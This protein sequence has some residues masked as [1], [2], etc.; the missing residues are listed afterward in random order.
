MSANAMMSTCD[1]QAV[2]R[3]RRRALARLGLGA[4]IAYVAP[5][6][7]MRNTLGTLA[8]KLAGRGN[9]PVTYEFGPR[10]LHSTGQLHKGGANNGVFL[11]LV[12]DAA[13]DLDVPEDSFTFG[14][15]VAAQA[16]GDAAA[17]LQRGRR[18]LR[19]DLGADPTSIENLIK[20]LH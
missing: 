6:P 15:L 12:D 18:F 7:E 14:Q 10:F 5:T 1:K 11:Q 17:L 19:I 3:D 4:S 2:D 9:N 20:A 13:N 8:C 16:D